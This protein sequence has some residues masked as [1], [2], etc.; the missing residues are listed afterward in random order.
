MNELTIDATVEN[1]VQVTSFVEEKLEALGCPMKA[2]MQ[3]SVA[4]DELFGNIAHYAY[5]PEVGPATVRVEVIRS[6]LAVVITFIDNGV[7]YD[8]LAKEDPDTALS[9]EEREIG[10]LGIY[11][12]KKSMDEIT[13]EYREGQNILRI[14]KNIG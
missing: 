5:N 7:Q 8:P 11:M 10:G 6:P 2:Q 1:I 13:Y 12:V 3:I 14:R 9:A 4:I